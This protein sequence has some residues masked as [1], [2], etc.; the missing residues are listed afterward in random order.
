MKLQSQLPLILTTAFLDILG[1]SLLIPSFPAITAHF[2]QAESWSMWTQAIYSFGMFLAGSIVGNLSDKYGRKNML[3]V[4]SSINIIGYL[5]TYFA[6]KLGSTVGFT[7]FLLYLGARFV[8]GIGGAGFGVVQAYISDISMGAEKTKNMGM[9]G[10]AF[11]MA[12]LIGPAIGGILAK[13]IGIEGLLLV[14]TVIIIANL[15]WIIYGLP[16]PR[17]HISEMSDVDILEWRMTGEIYFLLALSLL[18]TIGFSAMQGGSSQFT[19]DKFGFDSQMIGYSMAVVGIT[20]I[21]YQGFLVRFVRRIFD[22]K[23]MI[24]IGFFI[25]TVGFVLYAINPYAILV[26]F[27]G[28]LF[29]LGM[30]SFGPSVAALLSKDAGKHAGRVMGM[31]TSVSGIGGILGPII[32]G[33]LYAIHI[34][35]PYWVSAGLFGFLFFACLFY[36]SFYQSKE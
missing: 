15:L 34:E 10:A 22:E 31:N 2:G 12:F 7:G 25:L 29:P 14:S 36:F 26:Y 20:S 30:G 3:I 18:A 23:Q 9:M 4:T 33:V 8:A 11:G 13:Y 16:E 19:T 24:Q 35:L 32:V 6:L 28:I 27:I 5:A 17:E 21:I 1:M